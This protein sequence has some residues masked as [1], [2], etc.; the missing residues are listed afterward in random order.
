YGLRVFDVP[1]NRPIQRIDDDDVVYRT[2][3][4]KYKAIIEELRDCHQRGQPVLL[5]TASI[6]KSELL[7]TLLAQAKIPHQVLNA[8]H[9]EREALI[10]AQA[11][12][13][14][15]ITVATNMAGRG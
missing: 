4:E 3:K 6:E 7:S 10:I 8:R 13:P 9:H 5:G 11:G 14:G 15:A 2:A 1:T 12:M